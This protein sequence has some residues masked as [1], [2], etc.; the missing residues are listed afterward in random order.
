MAEVA[1]AI[2]DRDGVDGL[3]MRALAA[4]L[5]VAPST[6]YLHVRDKHELVSLVMSIV[7]PV[8]PSATDRGTTT[9]G[10]RELVIRIVDDLSAHPNVIAL[11]ES[12]M[13]TFI[14]C[15]QTSASA[16]LEAD[17]RPKG[18]NG[19]LGD[20]FTVFLVGA[21]LALRGDDGLP[22]KRRV[23]DVFEAYFDRTAT[24]ADLESPAED[25]QPRSPRRL[26]TTGRWHLVA[27]A[28]AP[29]R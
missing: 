9:C 5:G 29:G 21:L 17:P 20:A 27:Q 3:T 14:R 4:N 19:Q 22:D 28:S 15:I 26:A 25:P 11:G 12:N 7:L 18:R 10:M 1:L 2:V 24:T 16:S 13:S 23:V 6:L 8:R